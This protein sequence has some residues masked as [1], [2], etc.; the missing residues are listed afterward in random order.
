MLIV[1]E[2]EGKNGI[3][4]AFFHRDELPNLDGAKVHHFTVQNSQ[5]FGHAPNGANVK[6]INRFATFFCNVV[7]RVFFKEGNV[8]ATVRV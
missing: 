4:H 3:M 7:V 2:E 1:F 8:L 6:Q 5:A